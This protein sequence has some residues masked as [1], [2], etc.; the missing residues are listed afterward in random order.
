MFTGVIKPIKKFIDKKVNE[1]GAQYTAFGIF[2]VLNY[3]IFYFIWTNVSQQ[4]YTNLFL[5]LI[6]TLLCFALVLH[7]LWPRALASYLPLY[8]YVTLC[9]CLPFFFTYMLLKNKFGYLWFA[10]TV[11]ILFCLMLL[12]DWL[13]FIILQIIGVILAIVF[14]G[15]TSPIFIPHDANIDYKGMAITYVVSIVVGIVFAHNREILEKTKLMT[16]SMLGKVVAHE[17]RT[18]LATINVSSEN[19][20]NF[21]PS[22]IETYKIAR[23]TQLAQ[24]SV[25][26]ISPQQLS[27][28]GKAIAIIQN[29]TAAAFLFIDMLLVNIKALH[30][31]VKTDVFSISQCISDALG[32]Y[33][34]KLNQSELIH[35]NRANDYKIL[36]NK[37]VIEHVL[38][39]LLRN[40]LYYV[41]AAGKGKIYI[42]LE[43]G[44]NYNRL[45]FK[46]TG[47]GIAKNI[48]PRIFDQFFSKTRHGAG[49]GLNFCKVTMESLGG[50]I[51]CESLESEYTQFMLSF[52]KLTET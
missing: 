32:R 26:E 18:P 17:L 15:I 20:N 51:K 41:A 8:W 21:L 39:N 22:L 31:E 14:Y 11:V 43:Q 48:L 2:G 29:E 52:P 10:N 4:T 46:D 9:Y 35:F 28:L 16:M 50:K 30:Y 12:V 45:Y 37:L 24:S 36:G 7:K 13:S 49:I 3:P 23:K 38:F 42:W 6:A 34:F 40:A 1:M 19:I 47:A 5:R 27:S 33:P 44:D 25:K